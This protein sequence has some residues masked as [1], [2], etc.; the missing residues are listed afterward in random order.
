MLLSAMQAGGF[1]V[2]AA[3]AGNRLAANAMHADATSNHRISSP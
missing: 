3:R 1:G 2:S